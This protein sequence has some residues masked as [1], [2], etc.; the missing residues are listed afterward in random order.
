MKNANQIR[1]LLKEAMEY[2]YPNT[3]VGIRIREALALLPCET[4]NGTGQ[5]GTGVGEDGRDFDMRS[6]E[7][8]EPCPDCKGDKHE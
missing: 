6:P 7:I 1:Q 4:C 3:D 5:I 8:L 2:V